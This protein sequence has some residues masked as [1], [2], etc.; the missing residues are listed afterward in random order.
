MQVA[1]CLRFVTLHFKKYS[2]PAG[3]LLIHRA[4]PTLPYF[5]VMVGDWYHQEGRDFYFSQPLGTPPVPGSGN[6]FN[7]FSRGHTL[8]MVGNIQNTSCPLGCH[9]I[10]H[11][12][13]KKTCPYT[14]PRVILQ[15]DLSN[16]F[17]AFERLRTMYV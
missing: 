6:L 15:N 9:R 13:I 12:F 14:M 2:C 16:V 10:E 1:D 7:W 17:F 8:F 4:A 3:L 5:P 11:P